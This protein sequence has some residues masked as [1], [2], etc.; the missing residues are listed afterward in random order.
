MT[1]NGAKGETL[2]QME[3]T[4]GLSVPELNDYLH[5]YLQN[6]PADDKYKISPANS[7]WF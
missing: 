3:E 7:I 1:A 6:L 4:L 5:A 2:A